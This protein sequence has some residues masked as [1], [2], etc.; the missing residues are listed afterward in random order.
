MWLSLTSLT[1][2]KRDSLCSG[3]IHVVCNFFLTHQAVFTRN[4]W[5]YLLQEANFQ[6]SSSIETYQEEYEDDMEEPT[7]PQILI[8][9]V[10]WLNAKPG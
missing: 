7:I 8:N 3:E 2:G 9:C 1:A 5:S 6:S 4:M 10:D